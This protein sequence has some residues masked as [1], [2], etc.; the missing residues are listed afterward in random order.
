MSFAIKLDG[1]EAPEKYIRIIKGAI[2]VFSQKG[3]FNSKVSDVAK[4]A[5]VADGTIYLYF[6]NKDDVLLSVFEHSMDHYILQMRAELDKIETSSEKLKKFIFIHLKSVQENPEL[7]QVLQVELRSSTK[8]MKEYKPHKFFEYLGILEDII[9]QG[10][11]N[12][13]FKSD[14]SS[15]I[16]KRAVFG[17]IDEISLEWILM[18]RKR[19][20]IEEATEQVSSLILSGLI[21]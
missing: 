9:K 17:A 8:F 1:K 4:E 10:Q 14:I 15:E 2:Q 12:E 7:S 11:A 5:Q 16:L 18:N 3:F 20:T 6:K 21:I 19:Y 13:V